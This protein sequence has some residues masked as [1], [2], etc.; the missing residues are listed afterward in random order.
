MKSAVGVDVGGTF[1]KVGLVRGSRV[2]RQEVL[3]TASF[4][5]PVSCA[6]GIASAVRLLLQGPGGSIIGVGV[7]MPGL[8]SYPKG[9]VHSAVNLPGRW[10]EVPF[11]PM[12]R[13]ALH[14]PVH[15]DNDVNLMALAEWKL[16]AGRGTKNLLC[17]TLGT[18]VGGGLVLEGRLYRGEK[19]VAGEVGHIPVSQEGPRCN[20]GGRGCLE[21]YVGNRE[22]VEWVKRE[23][24]RG[25]KSRITQL[26]QGDLKRLTPEVIDRACRMNDPLAKQTWRRVGFLIG[27]ALS[28]VVNLIAPERIVVGG[29]VAEAG[30]PLLKAIRQT[31]RQRSMKGVR[32]VSVVPARLGSA[33][34]MIGAAL[35]V[36]GVGKEQ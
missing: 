26:V 13:R 35:L 6:R 10:K 36:Q 7:G 23:L 31:L 9:V 16:G 2:L 5:G 25:R 18:G 33:A 15:V 27:F 29:G 12:L 20:C 30:E 3:S 19:G 32:D 14:C 1:I 34:G 28:G 4:S 22:M 24:V 8:V 17:L 11:G 21:R